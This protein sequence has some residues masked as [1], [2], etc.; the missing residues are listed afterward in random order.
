MEHFD[1]V[2][3]GGGPA[4]LKCAELLGGTDLKIALIEKSKIIGPKICAG[5]VTVNIDIPELL[6]QKVTYFTRQHVILDGEEHIINLD[7]PLTVI[8]R[9]V[10]GK[11]Q[12]E[13][14][15]DYQNVKVITGI[16]VVQIVND[17]EDLS[18][19]EPG[20]KKEKYIIT[21]EG[22]KISFKFLVGAD[23]SRSLTRKFL[24]L[25][26]K[27]H[28]GAHYK[29][30]A[31]FDKVVWFLNPENLGTGYCWIFPHPG[32]TSC[33]VYY[34]PE[35]ISF[36]DSKRVLDDM[37]DDFGLDYSGA[38]FRGFP[39]NCLYKGLKFDDV[40]LCG[41]AAGVAFPVTGEGISTALECG[42]Y[43]AREILQEREAFG[44]IKSMLRHRRK[45]SRYLW[46]LKRIGNHHIQSLI[47]KLFI[48]AIR[49]SLVDKGKNGTKIH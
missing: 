28:I 35:L 13:L 40:Y 1:V 44:G 17:D 18:I 10:L 49:R 30:P 9:A 24:G 15:E 12:L 29:I 32:F 38:R 25:E 20:G 42:A 39:V 14:L 46:V 37:L 33:G 23:G 21:S 7:N 2:I 45:Q 6:S 31:V 19:S 4:G 16:R 5:G 43:V 36:S 41:D 22:E 11:F 34:D 27:F 8:D 47:F 3:I 26:S 48:Y